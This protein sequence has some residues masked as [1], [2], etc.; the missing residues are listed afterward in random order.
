MYE[1]SLKI[2]LIL[3]ALQIAAGM[4]Y[5][6]SCHVI[7]RDLALRNILANAADVPIVKIADLG[8]GRSA[9]DYYKTDSKTIPI[10]WS[11]PVKLLLVL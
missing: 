1:I 10:K 11:A 7:H 4:R 6:E 5:L 8:L 3:S 9:T 2:Q